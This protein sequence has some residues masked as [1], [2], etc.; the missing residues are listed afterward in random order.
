MRIGPILKKW[1]AINDIPIKVLAAEIGVVPSTIYNLESG[2]V[3][4]AVTLVKLL[5]W[6]CANL[7]DK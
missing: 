3:I 4:D 2:R 1:R 6:L 7:E 5:N